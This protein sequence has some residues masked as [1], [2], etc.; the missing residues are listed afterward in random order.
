MSS[1][2]IEF[3]DDR[4]RLLFAQ[5]QLGDQ[6]IEWMNSPVGQYVRGCAIQEIEDL[7][8]QLEKSNPMSLFG[9]RKIQRLQQDA[10]AARF[11]L[12]WLTEAINDGEN[13]YQQLKE[14]RDE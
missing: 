14:Y 1:S 3:L 9:R 5:A 6:T 2:Q 10:K 8:D 7:R 13:A 12:Q 4:E 11:V